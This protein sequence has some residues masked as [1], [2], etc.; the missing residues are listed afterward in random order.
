MSQ[1]LRLVVEYD[2]GSTRKVDYADVDGETRFRLAQ[3]GLTPAA[4]HVPTSSHYLVMRWRDGWQEVVAIDKESVELLRYY[5]IERI[6]DRGRLSLETG[7]E[8]PQLFIIERTPRDLTD[9]TIVGSDGAKSY[10]LDQSVDRWE[11]IFE[12]GGK[13]E[14]VKFDKT[15]EKYP[16]KVSDGSPAVR[17]ILDALNKQLQETGISAES[18]LARDEASRVADYKALAAG[19]NLRASR[20]QEDVYG[21]VEAMLTTL[22]G[23]AR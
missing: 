19:L 20:H 14:H 15:S 12:A 22:A 7:D 23:E 4:A 17:L 11:G 6:E 10:S 1:P 18:L 21:F 8:Y 2:D 16:Q 3:L 5:V 9:I 13:R